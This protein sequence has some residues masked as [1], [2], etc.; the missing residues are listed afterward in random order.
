MDRRS[1]IKRAAAAAV[2]PVLPGLVGSAA[3]SPTNPFRRLRPSD[4]DWPNAANWAKLNGEVRGR[5]IKVASPFEIC[6]GV[7]EAS[8]CRELFRELKNPYFIGDQVNLTQTMGW[9]DAWT[10]QPSVYAVAVETTQDVVAA[11]NFARDKNLR[12][13]VKGGGHSYL[14]TSNAP[15]SLL[16]WTRRMVA[17]TLHDD[18]VGE[19][20]VGREAPQPAVTVGAGAIWGHTYNKV[21]TEGGRYVQGGGCLTV[22]VA[23]LVQAG[24]F[25]SFSKNFGTAAAGLLGSRDRHRRRC[26]PHRQPLHQPRSF[27]G[28]QRWRR[29]QP[30]RRHPADPKDPRA[31]HRSSVWYRRRSLHPRR[32]L[33]AGWSAGLSI[34]MPTTCSIRIGLIRSRCDSAIGSTSV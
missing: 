31:A 23:G 14:G 22:G 4:P 6:R 3:S 19:G 34:S 17:M 2:M 30:R 7:P 8:A 28:A 16:I 9:V 5:L 26:R 13:V 33:F 21:T 1:L 25:G 20:C 27:L 15:N 18:F 12:L 10:S 32:R 11:V 24:G 29:W